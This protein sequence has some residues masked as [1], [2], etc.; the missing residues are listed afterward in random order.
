MGEDGPTHQPVEQVAALRAIPNLEVWRPADAAETGA[1]WQAALRRDAG[2]TALVL[3]RQPVPPLHADGTAADAERGG[4]VLR[5]E[6]E[7]PPELV[8]AA[9]GSEVSIS[10]EAAR[11]LEDEGRRVR[12]VS[13]PCL[14]RFSA[15]DSEYR[16]RVLPGGVPRLVVEAGVELGVAS[17]LQPGDRFH[18][19]SGFGAS[20]P[21]K[22]L[23][24]EFG[25]TP[26]RVAELARELLGS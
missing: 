8:I 21:W 16:E 19:M 24:V 2:P 14:E 23:A 20:A 26:E 3:T 18:G 11:V 12:L 10:L 13:L 6:P 4:Y 17:L 25:F 7:G 1:A 15:Q 9:T 22:D 5:R